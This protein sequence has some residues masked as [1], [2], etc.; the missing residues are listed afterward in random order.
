[1]PPRA[2]ASKVELAEVQL[3]VWVQ[4]RLKNE[5][6]DDD[7]CKDDDDVV[8]GHQDDQHKDDVGKVP[9]PQEQ[10]VQLTNPGEVAPTQPCALRC[11]MCALTLSI[12]I[13]K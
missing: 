1:M 12:L 11:T 9:V 4:I 10:D 6:A 7:K 2:V 3:Q 8:L 5:N 13:F